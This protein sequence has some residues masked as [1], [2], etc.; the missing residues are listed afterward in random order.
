[1]SWGIHLMIRLNFRVTVEPGQVRASIIMFELVLQDPDR[2]KEI[3]N[4]CYRLP[5]ESIR[6]LIRKR[7]EQKCSISWQ[8]VCPFWHHFVSQKTEPFF[9][10]LCDPRHSNDSGHSGKYLSDGRS[11]II[12]IVISWSSAWFERQRQAGERNFHPNAIEQNPQHFLSIVLSFP[13]NGVYA[14]LL[15][16][17]TIQ[18]MGGH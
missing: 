10:S 16:C 6:V 4:N 9:P 14:M 1:M 5:I 17:H 3:R 8:S 18:R 7:P 2:H 11:I 12:I 15:A 13:L